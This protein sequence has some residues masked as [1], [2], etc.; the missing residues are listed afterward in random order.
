MTY[1]YIAIAILVLGFLYLMRVSGK[2]IALMENN[3]KSAI[4]DAKN[5]H[6]ID[7]DFSSESIAEV[8]KIL[9]KLHESDGININELS[10]QYGAY[11]GEVMRKLESN[12][13]WVKDHTE[14]GDGLYPL[15]L[16]NDNYVFPVS[17]VDK[18]L[19]NGDEDNILH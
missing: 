3:S 19:T 12:G 18:H 15:K 10:M 6:N 4:S 1:V 17:W 13:L 2:I 5:N 9:Q 7:L 14:L 11:I 8:N 16:S